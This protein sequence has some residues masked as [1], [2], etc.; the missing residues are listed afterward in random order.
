MRFIIFI[1]GAMLIHCSQKADLEIK[2]AFVWTVDNSRPTEQAV[3]VTGNKISAVGSNDTIEQLVD[4]HTQIIDANGRMVMPG[5]NDAHLH[6]IGGGLALLQVNLLGCKTPEEIQERIKEKAAILPKG[7]W[8]IGRGW[9]HT[10]FNQ[11]LWPDKSLLDDI[12]QDHPI[13]VRRVDGHVG[14]ANGLAL[15]MAGIDRHTPNPDGGEILKHADGEP[16]GIVKESAMEMVQG[17]IPDYSFEQ[18]MFAAEKAVEL[19]SSLG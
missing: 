10:V 18:K 9:D 19:A 15:Q 8:I 2:N 11:G 13:F 14:W 6:F 16:T 3:A 4:K 7:Q 12:S 1:I 5:F 17:I